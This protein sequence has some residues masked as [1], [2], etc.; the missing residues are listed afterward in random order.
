MD[1]AT[2]VPRPRPGL[3]CESLSPLSTAAR[4]L[5]P[6]PGPAGSPICQRSLLHTGS[7]L[8]LPEEL[9]N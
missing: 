7:Q 6:L 3:L 8:R 9:P 4:L 5:M 2:L 1:A